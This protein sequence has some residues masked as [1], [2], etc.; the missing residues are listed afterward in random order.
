MHQ[1]EQNDDMGDH[2]M[3]GLQPIMPEP[4]GMW[5]NLLNNLSIA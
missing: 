5:L 4:Y 1:Q 3:G 2:M